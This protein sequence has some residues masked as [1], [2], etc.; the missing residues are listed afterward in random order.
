MRGYPELSEH[1]LRTTLCWIAAE[2]QPDR[3]AMLH[4]VTR[5]RPGAPVTERQPA[6]QAL[7]LAGS[8]LAVAT[9]LGVGGVARWALADGPEPGV[10]PL[11][12][13]TASPSG[14]APPRTTVAPPTGAPT[15]ARP[16]VAQ[17]PASVP[18]PPAKGKAKPKTPPA[19]PE[20]L[21]ADG[22]INPNTDNTEGRSDITLKVREP[23]RALRLTVRVAPTAGLTDQ[24]GT[25]DA[26]TAKINTSVVREQQ[27]L[28]FH[29][30]L[31]DGAT[32]DAGTYVF[33]ARYG[34]DNDG[35]RDA[36]DDTYAVT[37]TTVAAGVALDLDGGFA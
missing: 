18:P 27:T 33:T 1:E 26:A 37:A 36:G 15:P 35:G 29:F 13:A 31:A 17:P 22:S 34:Y 11:A 25:H 21:W 6:G 16:R 2:H 12:P 10:V 19:A 24:G 14:P 23:L 5:H 28:V 30:D 3:A 4:R 9:I 7:R 20:P 8:A 32:L